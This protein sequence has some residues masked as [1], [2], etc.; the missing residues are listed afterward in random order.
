MLFSLSR[1]LV[2]MVRLWQETLSPDQVDTVFRASRPLF[3][4]EASD[5]LAS[6]YPAIHAVESMWTGEDSKMYVGSAQF[7]C[8]AKDALDL[9]P[10][11]AVGTNL[12]AWQNLNPCCS[13][14][15]TP[16]AEHCVRVT[17]CRGAQNTT[18]AG[19]GRGQVFPRR[20]KVGLSHMFPR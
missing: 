18:S 11:C 9:R 1:S 4:G 20:K 7:P 13:P 19:S 14:K 16:N 2:A 3:F 10:I 6:R 15:G 5:A 17:P 8:A 12:N